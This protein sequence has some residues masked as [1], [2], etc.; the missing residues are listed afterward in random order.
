MDLAIDNPLFSKI[1]HG[2]PRYALGSYRFEAFD[3]C[4]F[5]RPFASWYGEYYFHHQYDWSWWGWN[6]LSMTQRKFTIRPLRTV[7]NSENHGEST[8]ASLKANI[9]NIPKH[10][11]ICNAKGLSVKEKFQKHWILYRCVSKGRNSHVLPWKASECQTF[12][13]S[14][15]PPDIDGKCWSEFGIGLNFWSSR[16]ST[17]PIFNLHIDASP[18]FAGC[19][20]IWLSE[21]W[22]WPVDDCGISARLADWGRSHIHEKLCLFTD[23]KRQRDNQLAQLYTVAVCGSSYIPCEWKHLAC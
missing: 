3:H 17:N 18:L 2:I 1:V 11:L 6:L 23:G 21:K 9:Y 19:C 12:G 15:L 8:L 10:V 20:P 22:T 13:I 14:D 7:Q 5:Y 4:N 16:N